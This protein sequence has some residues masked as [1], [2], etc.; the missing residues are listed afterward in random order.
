MQT[1]IGR[2]FIMGIIQNICANWAEVLLGHKYQCEKINNKIQILII[3]D[4][5]R[6]VSGL[7]S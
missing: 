4:D 2:E 3:V 6:A 7:R 1:I 5:L